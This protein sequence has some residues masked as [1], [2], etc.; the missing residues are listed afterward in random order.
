MKDSRRQVRRGGTQ[1]QISISRL[2][3]YW[4]A[5]SLPGW[6]AV[7]ALAS[8]QQNGAAQ[9][10]HWQLLA[11]AGLAVMELIVLAVVKLFTLADSI[12]CDNA[13][14]FVSISIP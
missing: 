3:R 7:A 11:F 6:R 1:G 5:W 2:L 10:D 14:D 12:N 8:G 4:L 9:R 13:I